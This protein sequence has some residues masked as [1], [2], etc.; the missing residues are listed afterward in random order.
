MCIKF[1]NQLFF[2][3]KHLQKSIFEK[4][5]KTIFSSYMPYEKIFNPN[6]EFQNFF[7]ISQAKGSKHQVIS[8]YCTYI[9]IEKKN[10]TFFVIIF[11]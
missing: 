8:N 6:R 7:P 3:P 9:H 11:F 10:N 5:D 2:I 4:C 1:S